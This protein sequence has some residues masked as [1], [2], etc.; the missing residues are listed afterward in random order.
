MQ[1]LVEGCVRVETYAAQS[2]TLGLAL[3]FGEQTSAET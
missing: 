3:Q 1:G 2:M